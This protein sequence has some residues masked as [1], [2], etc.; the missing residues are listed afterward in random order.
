MPQWCT[1]GGYSATVVTVGEYSAT[2]V[3]VGSTVPQWCTRAGTVPQWCTRAGTVPPQPLQWGIQC[4]HSRYSGNTVPQWCTRY[5]E[6]VHGGV[7]WSA[8]WSVPITPGTPPHRPLPRVHHHCTPPTTVMH[9]DCAGLSK[10]DKTVTN[11]CLKNDP[12]AYK[13]HRR[14]CYAGLSSLPNPGIWSISYQPGY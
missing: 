6:G 2:V 10:I 12:S 3:T 1:R 5:P 14:T 7:H 4:H 9:R 8:P 13:R 11:G